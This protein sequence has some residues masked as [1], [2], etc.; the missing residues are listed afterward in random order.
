MTVTVA[1]VKDQLLTI[2]EVRERL[3]PTEHLLSIPFE[4]D[5]TQAKFELPPGWNEGLKDLP[6]TQVTSAK[7]TI[8]GKEWQLTKDA[9]LEATSIIQL[10]KDYVCKTPGPLVEMHLNYWMSH[11]DRHLQ[12]LGSTDSS[13]GL[14]FT[15]AS[16]SP[17]SNSR[18]LDEALE[19]IEEHY[20]EGEVLADYKF[21]HDLRRTSFRLIIP[22]SLRH[23]KSA[24]DGG[25]EDNWS[26]GVSVRNSLTGEKPLSIA[27]YTFAYWCTNGSISTHATS[28]NYNRKNQG[29]GDSVYEWAKASID[30][31]LGG[32]EHEL[33]SISELV[34]TELSSKGELTDT[35]AALFVKYAVPLASREHIMTALVESNDLTAYGLMQAIT[36]AANVPDI[37]DRQVTQLMMVGGDIPHTM[38]TRCS[39][40]HRFA[41]L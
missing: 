3:E 17:F 41:E 40:C 23:I 25:V 21:H 30:E 31:I 28:G 33:E 19:S 4:T 38:S 35:V 9:A 14:A 39:S 27:G 8:G 37:H 7:V 29:Q 24:R 18:L 12:L 15:K 6:G 26:A 34:T 10:T 1:D 20:G 22:E 13:T 36:S 32:L 2:D 16:I 11:G 5:T